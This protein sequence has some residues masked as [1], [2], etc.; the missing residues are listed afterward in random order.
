M[1]KNRKKRKPK[2][3]WVRSKKRR[4]DTKL[5]LQ[6]DLGE[7]IVNSI[8]EDFEILETEFGPIKLSDGAVV[9]GLKNKGAFLAISSIGDEILDDDHLEILIEY[10]RL[11]QEFPEEPF[12][13]VQIADCYKKLNR[14]EKYFERLEE[15]FLDYQ[16][17]P[18]VDIEYLMNL[19]DVSIDLYEST[20]GKELN[21]H[22][23]YQDFKAFD[24]YT[25]TQFY[26]LKAKYYVKLEEYETARNCVAIVKEIDWM[27]AGLLTHMISSASDPSFRRKAMIKRGIFVVLLLGIIGGIFWGIIKLLRWIF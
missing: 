7:L 4:F 14:E 2:K 20:F 11:N 10:E 3:A 22:K 18:L 13:H 1:A 21:I 27:E 17:Y 16:G 8:K 19:E 25:V 9:Y 6:N 23:V 12:I 26:A 5:E 15:N 24:S